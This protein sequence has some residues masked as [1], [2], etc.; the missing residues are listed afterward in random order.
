MR[1]TAVITGVGAVAGGVAGTALGA[2]RRELRE[3]GIRESQLRANEQ[4]EFEEGLR[5]EREAAEAAKKARAAVDA[6]SLGGG[7][8]AA[9]AAMRRARGSARR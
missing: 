9:A 7:S 5:R 6:G 3:Q 1:D 8:A 4:F 2:R